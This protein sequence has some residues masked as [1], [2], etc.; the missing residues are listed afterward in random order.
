MQ[1]IGEVVVECC[2]SM[3]ITQRRAEFKGLASQLEGLDEIA[4]S[5]VSKREV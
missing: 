2:L 5:T 4:V 3:A 1:E